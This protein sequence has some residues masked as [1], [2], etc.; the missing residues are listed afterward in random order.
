MG[1]L[2]KFDLEIE[3]SKTRI[4]PFGRNSKTKDKRAYKTKH[5]Y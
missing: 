1:R 4:F 5:N 2:A 3:T